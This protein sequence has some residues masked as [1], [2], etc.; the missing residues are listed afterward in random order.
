MSLS[1]FY[2]AIKEIKFPRELEL[3]LLHSNIPSK[4]NSFF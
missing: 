2:N 1:K 3:T 4:I